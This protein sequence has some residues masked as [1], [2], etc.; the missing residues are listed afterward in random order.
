MAPMLQEPEVQFAQR[1][2]SN[3]KSVRTKAI[4]KLRKYLSVRSQKPDGGFTIDE[5]L[6]IWKGLFY[7]L[8]MQDKPLQQEQL[9]TQISGLIHSLQNIDSQF[10]F[11]ESFLLTINREWNGIDR[12][13]MD[14]FYSLVRF[15]FRE[16]FEMMKRREWD[17]GLIGRFTELLS[18]QVL[19][20][21]SDAPKGVQ[22]HVL[23]IYM[24]ELA[25]VGSAQLTAE[26]NLT[27]IDPFCKTAA[28][29]KDHV[30]V[31]GICSNIFHE[32]VDHAPFAIEDLMREIRR[33]GGRV[34]KSGQEA[35]QDEETASTAVQNRPKR[36]G[37]KRVNGVTGT[38]DEDAADDDDGEEEAMEEDEDDLPDWEDDSDVPKDDEGIGPVLQF[39]YQALADRLFELASRSNTPSFN[40]KKLYN[41]VKTFRNLSKGVFPQDEYPAEVSTDEDDDDMFGSRRKIRK[42]RRNREDE[43]KEEAGEEGGPAVKKRKA[44]RDTEKPTDS[45][46]GR[47]AGQAD[48][49]SG[50]AGKPSDGAGTKKKKKRR[51]RKKKKTAV[52]AEG[53]NVPVEEVSEK[54]QTAQLDTGAEQA[55]PAVAESTD[56]EVKCPTMAETQTDTEAQNQSLTGAEEAVAD[57]VS[58]EGTVKKGK[59]KKKKQKVSTQGM[60]V[61]EADTEGLNTSA[62]VEAVP[63]G[64]ESQSAPAEEEG[65]APDEAEATPLPPEANRKRSKKKKNRETPEQTEGSPAAAEE[66]MQPDA[67]SDCADASCADAQPKK[68]KRKKKVAAAQEE[69]A[70]GEKASQINGHVEEVEAAGKKAKQCSESKAIST[71]AGAKKPQKKKKAKVSSGTASDFITFQSPC[72]P[73][74]LFCRQAKGS[75]S[76]PVFQK[77]LSLTPLSESKKVTFGL[78]NNQTAEFRKMDRSLMVSPDGSSRVPFDPQQ[79]PLF[80]VLKSPLAV[81]P[82][83]TN[84]KNDN[85]GTKGRPTAAD[86]F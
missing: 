6:K 54:Q 82:Q 81:K 47:T 32:I 12:L 37:G 19:R 44:K 56:S 29:T 57:G 42:R 28:K 24:T 11:V 14:K 80:G 45:E 48:S 53:E 1:L 70:T 85:S 4:K 46:Q 40:R 35:E 20:S 43:P 21:T 8:W 75:P 16:T 78:K 69:E 63:G 27:F 3:E 74:P 18:A 5:L 25:R 71:P 23:D 13:R 39:D 2:A 65:A 10:F 72:I 83:A 34:S 49:V 84:D 15:V 55:S 30:L 31:E 26:Q 41:V 58:S 38:V 50:P 9:S 17:N 22:F 51:R 67:E 86:F 62:A 7:C 59:K 68:R 60:E 61:S 77:Q 76:T 79:K 73:T 66:P 52:G 36:T 64:E 33:E